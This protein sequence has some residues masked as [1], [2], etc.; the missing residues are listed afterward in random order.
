VYAPDYDAHV[1]RDVLLDNVNSEPINRG[2]DDESIQYGDFTYDRLTLANC[3]VGR[4]PLIQL[5]CTSPRPGVSGHFRALTIRNSASHDGKVVDLG[6]GPRNSKLENAVSYYFHDTPAPGVVTRVVSVKFPDAMRDGNYHSIENWTGS[7]VRAAEVNDVPFPELLAPVDDLPP[8][9]LVTSVRRVGGKLT[10][11][12]VAE[13]NG[14][15]ASIT[16][17]GQLAQIVAQ[18]DGV[19]DWEIILDA[20]AG[21]HLIAQSTDRAGNIERMPHELDAPAP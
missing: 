12:G 2:H 19:A 17:N 18:Q 8:A 10:I 20:A 14:A 1:Y 21:A 5:T 11:R 13:D 4:D 16:V 6:G 15:I 7:D 3:R 9:T